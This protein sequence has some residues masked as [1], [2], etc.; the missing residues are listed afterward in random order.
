MIGR[1]NV[2]IGNLLSPRCSFEE[3]ELQ[4]HATH[5][6]LFRRKGIKVPVG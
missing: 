3:A 6:S 4:R 1:R 2:G 5:N